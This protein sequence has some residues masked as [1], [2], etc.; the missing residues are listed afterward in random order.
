MAVFIYTALKRDGS[1]SNGELTANDRADAF[2]RLDRSG[3][4][5]VSLKPKDGAA[6]AASTA[7]AKPDKSIKAG[8][9]DTAAKAGKSGAE[10]TAAEPS[11]PKSAAS[12]KASLAKASAKVTKAAEAKMDAVAKVDSA[13]PK[14]PIKLTRK[15]IIM[16][17]EEL[18]DLLSAGL[19][20]EPALRIMES[21]DELSALKDVTIILQK[22]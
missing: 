19:Q 3:L 11:K 14:G 7:P 12:E 17:T 15:Q 22:K 1:I 21:R 16:F 9:Q 10:E 13:I 4:Q 2:R 6:V 5:P 20:L 8:K 18:S